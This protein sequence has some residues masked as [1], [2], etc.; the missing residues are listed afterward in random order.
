M[1]RTLL[2]ATLALVPLALVPL[3]FG[4]NGSQQSASQWPDRP[5]PKV[6][7]SF[8]PLYCFAANVAGD[9]AVVKN[10]MTTS[11][12][13]DFNPT[14]EDASILQKAD[15]FFINGL[16]LDNRQAEAMKK[17][18]ENTNLK[19]VDLGSKL[20]K[21]CLMEG[22]CHHVHK[23]GEP[24]V[25]GDDPHVWLGPSRAI[26]MV[27]GI[28]DALKQADPAHAANYDRRAAEYIAKL[29]KVKEDGLA[30][31]KDKTERKIVTFH[32]SMNYFADEFKLSVFDVVQ[33]KP[34]SEPGAEDVQKLLKRCAVAGVGVI[35]V[36]PQYSRNQAAKTLLEELQHKGV[37]DARFVEFDPLE[38]VP[39][40]E[41][42]PDWYE[43]KMRENLKNLAEGLK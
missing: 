9:D 43:K 19:I 7:V 16:D 40:G 26:K 22:V 35:A 8:A 13:H 5:G 27:E 1:I 20:D 17:G 12:P 18:L 6:V 32:E 30:M 3:G 15:L 24:H 34:G 29:N 37:K 33:S 38:T 36:E 25:H 39:P 10:I 41:L 4:C 2:L 31:L 14:D 42:T 21:D 11:G 28:R 23:P